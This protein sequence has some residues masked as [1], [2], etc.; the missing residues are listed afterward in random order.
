MLVSVYL[1]STVAQLAGLLLVAA[2]GMG[3]PAGA[4][5]QVPDASPSASESPTP[6]AATE[7]V[8]AKRTRALPHPPAVLQVY[9]T[10]C[11]QCHDVDGRGEIA[12]DTLP[13]IPDFTEPK[14]QVSRNDA[15]LSHSIL[16]G[17]GKSMPRMKDKLGSADVRQ[18]VALVRGFR[19]GDQVI[20]DEPGEP[21]APERPAAVVNPTSS[22]PR[23]AEPP[24]P[25][26]VERSI[27][28]GSRLFQRS[29]AMCHG[30]DGRG[31]GVRATMPAIPDFT[32]R[33]WHQRRTD[34]QLVVSILEGKGTDMPS[35]RDKVAR[36]QA[37]DLVA[38]LRRFAPGTPPQS[39][40]AAPDDFDTRFRLLMEE[41][42]SVRR[43]SS[44]GAPPSA[45]PK[46]QAA[47][48]VR[49]TG[50]SPTGS[51]P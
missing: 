22:V 6:K 31:S 20:D 32:A 3:E 50:S 16:D 14:W 29:C 21:L 43:Q 51:Q 2:V 36:E 30:S 15:Q 11:V 40:G 9:R 19:G 35:F 24:A 47:P 27:R 46:S 41:F 33:A 10:S 44:A 38:F 48:P 8:R 28:E 39:A 23:P 1:R 42:H 7:P 49:V 37:R 25:S 17:K 26:M 5:G 34:P 4:G 13:R 18:M 45:Q 12:R